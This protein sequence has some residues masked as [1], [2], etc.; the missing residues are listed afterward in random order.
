MATQQRNEGLFQSSP[1]VE[2]TQ[3]PTA[4][5]HNMDLTEDATHH[6]AP[7]HNVSLAVEKKYLEM[8]NDKAKDTET[9]IVG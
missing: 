9:F 8:K 1:E 5:A 2:I 7:A 4:Q 3:Q 6:A